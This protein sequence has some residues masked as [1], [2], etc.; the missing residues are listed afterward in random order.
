MGRAR[1]SVR[2]A[3]LKRRAED[4]PPYRLSGVDPRNL[5]SKTA[6]FC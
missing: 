2:V 5:L 6:V 4:C 1:H 3:D